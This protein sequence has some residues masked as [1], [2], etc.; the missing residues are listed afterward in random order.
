MKLETVRAFSDS[1]YDYYR[2]TKPFGM[3]PAGT[4]FVH[5]PYDNMYGSPAQGCLKNCQAPDGSCYGGLCGGTVFLHYDFVNTD[6]FEKVEDTFSDMIKD[7]PAGDYDLKV[8]HN[9]TWSLTRHGSLVI[10]EHRY[11]TAEE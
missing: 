2:L 4:I 11:G 10:M 9:G 5:D 8:R 3:L 1:R 6:W 7:I